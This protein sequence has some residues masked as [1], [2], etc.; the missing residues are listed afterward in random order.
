MKYVELNPKGNF[1]SS[2][3]GKLRELTEIGNHEGVT[4]HVIYQDDI[5]KLRVIT[6]EP[7]ER[8]PFQKIN[9]NYSITCITNG[10]AISRYSNGKITLVR[11]QKGDTTYR[12]IEGETLI[13]DF[14]N[15]GE[16][17]LKIVILEHKT[18]L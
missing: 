8:V 11:F 13:S 3:A 16:E 14:Q 10:L 12:E 5:F 9:E 17:V 15:I 18:T 4:E 2:D 6:L 1:D 7:Y